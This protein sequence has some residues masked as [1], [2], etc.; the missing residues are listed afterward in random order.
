MNKRQLSRRI[1]DALQGAFQTVT[2]K[3][4]AESKINGRN[5]KI[6]E[7]FEEYV[8]AFKDFVLHRQMSTRNV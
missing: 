8:P 2:I 1:C 4:I 6:G 3:D 5:Q 7:S